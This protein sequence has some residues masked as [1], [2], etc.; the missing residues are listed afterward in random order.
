M[1]RLVSAEEALAEEYRALADGEEPLARRF[2]LVGHLGAT[3]AALD[4]VTAERDRLR[5][6]LACERGEKAP[7]GWSFDHATCSWS[8]AGGTI[9]TFRVTG[10]FLDG[11]EPFIR[12]EWI[13]GRTFGASPTALEAIE[14]ADRAA[15]PK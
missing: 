7:E 13:A 4:V 1:T 10:S 15:D 8:M 3:L 12:W 2:A 6:I 9:V 5:D 11:S 14:A